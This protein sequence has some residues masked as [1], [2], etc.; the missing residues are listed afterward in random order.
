M[1]PKSRKFFA[2][3]ALVLA[4][5]GCSLFTASNLKTALDG[6]ALACVFGSELT[7]AAALATVCKLDQALVP[8]VDQ[9]IAQR[10]AA[11]ASGVTW[12]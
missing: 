9:L 7:A 6:S 8:V 1:A 5:A 12:H 10:Q 4:L 2:A 11:K 3:A